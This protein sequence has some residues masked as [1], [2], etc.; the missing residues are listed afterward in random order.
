[1]FLNARVTIFPILSHISSLAITPLD[2]LP[3][4]QRERT[5]PF[6]SFFLCFFPI[7]Y[8]FLCFFFFICWLAGIFL[9]YKNFLAFLSPKKKNFLVGRRG[10]HEEISGS[11]S[12][13]QIL[14]CYLFSLFF[15]FFFFFFLS[16]FSFL[17]LT[18]HCCGADK[19]VDS[20]NYLWFELVRVVT[21]KD[22]WRETK[23]EITDTTK[24]TIL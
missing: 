1:M 16:S 20:A 15:F 21:A 11:L 8:F 14:C 3:T 4:Y 17:D 22:K 13:S 7:F 19:R 5:S 2:F 10:D 9:F 6:H 23:G 18:F 24:V 12:Y